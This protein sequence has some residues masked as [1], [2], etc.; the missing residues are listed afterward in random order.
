MINTDHVIP[1]ILHLFLW[2]TDVLFNQKFARIMEL[3]ELLLLMFHS[4]II[5]VSLSSSLTIVAK[6]HSSFQWIKK[7][8]NL[9]GEIS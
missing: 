5:V 9:N 4:Q 2:I 1:D 6:C 7:L 3:K 8:N